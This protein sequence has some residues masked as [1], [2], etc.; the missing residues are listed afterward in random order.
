MDFRD[1]IFADQ[2][3]PFARH[4]HGCDSQPLNADTYKLMGYIN[5]GGDFSTTY[6]PSTTANAYDEVSA[7]AIYVKPD[8]YAQLTKKIQKEIYLEALEILV[9]DEDAANWFI[10]NEVRDKLDRKLGIVKNPLK[11][12]KKACNT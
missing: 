2:A 3:R 12:K 5:Q 10:V 7:A 6:V 1:Y 9:Y 11:A 8:I 4:Y